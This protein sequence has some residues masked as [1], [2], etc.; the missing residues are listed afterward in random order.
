MLVASMK[1][2]FLQTRIVCLKCSTQTLARIWWVHIYATDAI[3]ICI[4]S[5]LSCFSVV[6][7]GFFFSVLYIIR[8]IVQFHCVVLITHFCSICNG[9]V[10]GQLCNTFNRSVNPSPGATLA[11]SRLLSCQYSC[12]VYYSSYSSLHKATGFN[13]C[14]YKPQNDVALLALKPESRYSWL[15]AA[16]KKLKR[17]QTA[18]ACCQLQILKYSKQQAWLVCAQHFSQQEEIISDGQKGGVSSV[19]QRD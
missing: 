3:N 12:S 2:G 7:W 13:A 15:S 14:F 17:T 4:P 10:S 1:L 8:S 19:Y 6:C 11:T 5:Q 16:K 18:T 9:S